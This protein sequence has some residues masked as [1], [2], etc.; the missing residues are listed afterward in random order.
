M[1]ALRLF[2]KKQVLCNAVAVVV[3]TITKPDPFMGCLVSRFHSLKKS[4]SVT[5]G[6]GLANKAFLEGGPKEFLVDLVEKLP[7]LPTQKRCLLPKSPPSNKSLTSTHVRALARVTE[8]G[9][10]GELPPN[11]LYLLEY[12]ME[13]EQ[14][15]HIVRWFP[16]FAYASVDK[17]LRPL[18]EFLLELGVQKSDIPRILTSCP[19]LYGAK[20]SETLVR[21]MTVLEKLGMDSKMWAKVISK[22]PG[23]VLRSRGKIDAAVE[24]LFQMGVSKANIGKV[25]KRYPNIICYN[26][27]NCLQPT[28]EYFE[29]LGIDVA[30]LLVRSPSSFGMSIETKLKPVTEFFL[31]RGF[32]LGDIRTMV[33]RYGDMY[34]LSLAQNLIPKWNFFLTLNYPRLELVRVPFYFGSSLEKRIK[35]R[36]AVLKGCG[37]SMS[38]REVVMSTDRAFEKALRREMKPLGKVTSV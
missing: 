34:C 1:Y 18:V 24:F 6:Q 14:I 10:T 4:R 17:K 36:I 21:N 33:S 38:L 12:G 32:S 20:P 25:L 2:A 27:E 15:M 22:Y 16:H 31:E 26:V 37:V 28:A 23:L 35:P 8:I 19:L 29:S 7:H 30:G 13:L 11:V 3:R 9:P 5:G